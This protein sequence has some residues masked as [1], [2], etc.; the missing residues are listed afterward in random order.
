M[1]KYFTINGKAY[2]STDTVKMKVGETIK[3]RFI[4]S[5]N[6]FVH[7]MHVHGGPFTVVAIDGNV[8]QAGARFDADTVDVGPGQRYDVIWT[9]REPGKWLIHCHIPHHTTNNNVEEHG[10]GGLMM[11]LDVGR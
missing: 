3:L 4:G 10:G 1:P 2:P 11:I 5:N 8:L 9:A 7:P 6:N